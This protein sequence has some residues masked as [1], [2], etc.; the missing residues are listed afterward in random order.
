M[1]N[2]KAVRT[3]VRPAVITY[4]LQFIILNYYS[5]RALLWAYGSQEDIQP[6]SDRH[7]RFSH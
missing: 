1:V 6:R 7:F 3:T 5:K 2:H 4:F